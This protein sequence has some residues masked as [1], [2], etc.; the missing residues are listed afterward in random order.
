MRCGFY[1]LHENLHKLQFAL[2]LSPHSAILIFYK[3][4]HTRM[5][6]GLYDNIIYPVPASVLRSGI[7][8]VRLSRRSILRLRGNRIFLFY[9]L[10]FPPK[11]PFFLKCLRPSLPIHQRINLQKQ[12]CHIFKLKTVR[13]RPAVDHSRNIIIS[14]PIHAYSDIIGRKQCAFVLSRH[15]FLT[16]LQSP[17]ADDSSSISK[18]SIS[19]L[20]PA[21]LRNFPSIRSATISADS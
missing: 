8:F 12:T 6:S 3:S 2:K 9:I 16:T 11:G 17:S 20:F 4:L 14:I 21:A 13:K 5:L 10:L 1:L 15:S 7:A 18:C 19:L